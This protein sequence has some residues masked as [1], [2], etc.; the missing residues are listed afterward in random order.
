M[1]GLCAR[2]THGLYSPPPHL[3]S[4]PTS[5]GR[6]PIGQHRPAD[7]SS[8]SCVPLVGAPGSSAFSMSLTGNTLTTQPF[9]GALPTGQRA[10]PRPAAC[11]RRL[12][13]SRRARC[14]SSTARS[15]RYARTPAAVAPACRSLKLLQPCCAALRASPPL[16]SCSAASRLQ[17]HP[18]TL[19]FVSKQ[20]HPATSAPLQSRNSSRRFFFQTPSTPQDIDAAKRR[21]YSTTFAPGPSHLPAPLQASQQGGPPSTSEPSHAG[22]SVQEFRVGGIWGLKCVCVCACVRVRVCVCVCVPVRVL[23]VQARAP[24]WLCAANQHTSIRA[25]CSIQLGTAVGVA[26]CSNDSAAPRTHIKQVQPR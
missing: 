10:A 22:G 7:H 17:R 23:T 15:K 18:W 12:R 9:P 11:S 24:T 4:N 3:H 6:G 26:R 13:T 20:L 21:L 25:V 14:R 5:T 16:D 1:H 2:R 19:F 8:L